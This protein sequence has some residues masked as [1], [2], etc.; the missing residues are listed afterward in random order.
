MYFEVLADYIVWHCILSVFVY[1]F[2]SS[3]KLSKQNDLLIQVN[4]FES[5]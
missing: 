5:I 4:Y 1:V 3:S 2:T